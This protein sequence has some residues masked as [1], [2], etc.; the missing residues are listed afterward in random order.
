MIKRILFGLLAAAALL[1][2]VT[3]C[4]TV[5]GAGED[6]ELPAAQSNVPPPP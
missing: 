2:A 5:G 4:S 1:T 6:V 3:G